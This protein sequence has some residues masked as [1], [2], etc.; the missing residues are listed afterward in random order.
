MK[1]LVI[2]SLIMIVVGAV[3]CGAVY[4]VKGPSILDQQ[5]L[6]ES[7][8]DVDDEFTDITVDV[9]HNDV[10]LA[11]ARDGVCRVECLDR[12][13][14]EHG[15]S[16]EDGT[17]VIT[18][19]EEEKTNFTFIGFTNRSPVVTIYLPENEYGSLDINATSGDI[20][21]E[22][23]IAFAAV[24]I[25]VTSG[26]VSIVHLDMEGDITLDLVTGD[27]ELSDV[28]CTNLIYNGTTGDIGL[29]NVIVAQQMKIDMLTGDVLFDRS[30]AFE[31][32]VDVTTGD[33]EGVLLTAK[34]FDCSAVTGD[35]SVPRDGN[36]GNCHIHVGTGD[37]FI[38]TA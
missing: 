14:M 33:I 38:Q 16:V 3:I 8:Y 7:S 12:E 32:S 36:G 23:G 28:T 20:Y 26:D 13:G 18:S 35:I 2:A 34:S 5:N 30:D 27:A 11:A 29:H 15:V 1:K 25:S 37:V 4:A 9:T 10:R 31:I 22:D 6:I 19:E 24:D 21:L 17:L